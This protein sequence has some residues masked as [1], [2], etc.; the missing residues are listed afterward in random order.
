VQIPES[1]PAR[2]AA[3]DPAAFSELVRDT[4]AGLYRFV[5]RYVGDD[6]EAYDIVQDAYASAW[7]AIRR[8]DPDRSFEA[9]IRVI[10]VNKCRDWSRRRRVRRFLW[11]VADLTSAEALAV[12]DVDADVE[13]MGVEADEARR[14]ARAISELP[15]K[16]KEAL[17]LTAIEGRS[18]TEAAEILGVTTKAVETRVAR[19]RQT[20]AVRLKDGRG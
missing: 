6:E 19:A 2:A 17:L 14:L 1:A 8:Y 9:W 7:L 13:R 15:D 11:P 18:Q 20:L 4:K 12:A 16:Q 5:R 10:A 3:G